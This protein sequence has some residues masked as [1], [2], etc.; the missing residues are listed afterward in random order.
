MNDSPGDCRG[1]R[2]RSRLGRAALATAAAAATVLL[3]AACGD[4]RPAAAPSAFPSEWTVQKVDAFAQCVRGHGVAGFYFS[5]KNASAA[6]STATGLSLPGWISTPITP[7]S[8]VLQSALKA[9]HHLLGL[10][11]QPVATSGQLRS[12]LKAAACLRA[13]GYPGY[14]DPSELNGQIVE[15]PLP[16]SIDTS[17][18]RFQAAQQTCQQGT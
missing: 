6:D 8:P 3:A 1:P 15:P 9:C 11:G 2:G 7:G 10:H 17:S 5:R 13:H 4:G 18:P 16:T 12:Q 14:P